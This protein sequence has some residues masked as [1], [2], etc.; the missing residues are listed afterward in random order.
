MNYTVKFNGKQITN[1]ETSKRGTFKLTI[2]ETVKSAKITI[3]SHG[4]KLNGLFIILSII[5]WLGLLGLAGF[6][7]HRQAES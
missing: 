6:K 1:P 3:Q 5:G 2:P 4:S 7:K